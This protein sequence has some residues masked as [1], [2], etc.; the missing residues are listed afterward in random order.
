MGFAPIAAVRNSLMSPLLSFLA[1][2]WLAGAFVLL[3]LALGGWLLFLR[4]RRQKWSVPLLLTTC[5]FALAGVGGLTVPP[6]VGMWVAIGSAALLFGMLLWLIL[7]GQWTVHVSAGIAALLLVGLGGWTAIP[8]GEGLIDL[9]KTLRQVEAVQPAW[10]WGLLIIPLLIYWSRRSLAGMGPARR[11]MA[12]TLRSILVLFLLLALAEVRWRQVNDTVTTLF[13][14]D[15]SLSVPEQ[16]DE[17]APPDPVPGKTR[18]VDHRWERIKKFI[19]ESVEKR[20]EAHKRDKAGLIVFARR[21]RLELPPSDAP[22]F[23]FVDVASN[24]DRNYTDIAAAIKLALASFPE[25]SAK[26]IVLISDGNEN[27]GNAEEQARIAR[28][29]GVQIDVVPLARGQKNQN[30]VLVQSVEVPPLTEQG[31]RFPIRVLIRSYN[32]NRVKGTL[33]LVQI[34]E[35]KE[36]HVPPSPWGDVTLTPGVNPIIFPPPKDRPKGSFTYRAK[37]IPRVVV[38]DNGEEK[39]APLGRLQNKEASSHVLALGQRRVLVVENVR[40]D[41]RPEME[42]T[43]LVEHLRG[44][45]ESKFRVDHVRSNQLPKGKGDL[46]VFLSNYDCLILANLPSEALDEDQQEVVRGNTE[47]QGCGLIMIGGPDSFGAGGWQGTPV[48]KALP[49]DCSAWSAWA[50]RGRNGTSRSRPWATSGNK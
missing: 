43:F 46:A 48:E 39:P 18:P 5:G 30:E 26:R 12:I 15:R 3:A 1:S 16:V 28:Q 23:N 8:A 10:L 35:G 40:E 13:L 20:G 42:H 11:W 9:G 41:G 25:S 36:T 19:N 4:Q 29:N 38:M 37:F 49:V 32:P 2:R 24:L 45:G 34:A 14:V 44:V 17:Q 33:E 31:S 7:T 22:R 50:G 27:L 47:D 21:P 6:A